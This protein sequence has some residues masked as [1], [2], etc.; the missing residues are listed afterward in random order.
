M[1]PREE[2]IGSEK[3]TL[4]GHTLI[5]RNDPP[6]LLLPLRETMDRGAATTLLINGQQTGCAHFL[7]RSWWCPMPGRKRHLHSLHCADFGRVWVREVLRRSI[8]DTRAM[9]PSSRP[10][11]SVGGTRF[12]YISGV[13]FLVFRPRVGLSWHGGVSVL[14]ILGN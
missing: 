5:N 2:T 9:S 14:L 11:K 6:T 8:P 13:F 1:N 7:K 12:I 4:L 10:M 3:S